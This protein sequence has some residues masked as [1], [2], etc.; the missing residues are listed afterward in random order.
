MDVKIRNISLSCRHIIITF[1][2]KFISCL[3]LEFNS[4]KLSS[5]SNVNSEFTTKNVKKLD[6]V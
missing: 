5:A 2:A 4:S 6:G 3:L 1:A